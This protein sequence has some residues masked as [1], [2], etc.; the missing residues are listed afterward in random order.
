MGADAAGQQYV[1]MRMFP[2][3]DCG[4]TRVNAATRASVAAAAARVRDRWISG[5]SGGVDTDVIR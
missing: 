1:K 3:R 2:R 4:D 5:F